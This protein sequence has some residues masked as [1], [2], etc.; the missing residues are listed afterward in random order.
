MRLDINT[1]EVVAFTVKLEKIR[2]S[3]L[4]SAVRGTLNNAAFDVKQ[5]TMPAQAAAAFVKRS[6]NFFKANS[7][8]VMATGFDVNRMKATV[9]FVENKLRMGSDHNFAVKDLEQQ[10][11]S[12]RIGGKSFIPLDS[13]RVSGYNSL[14]KPANRLSKILKA[15]IVI[16]RNLKGN[17]KKQQFI[18]A[19]A[20]AGQ[21]GYVIGSNIKGENILWRV[22]TYAG[23]NKFTL[24]PL[25]SFR[26]NRRVKVKETGFME[27]ATLNSAEKLNSF[28]IAQARFYLNKY[29]K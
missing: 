28:Y 13:A 18:R 21:G 24:T 26:K 14:V 9:G 15:K 2:K 19:V 16:A 22:D 1:N 20:K 29:S 8:V 17:S 23:P 5:R 25:Y 10:E 11:H 4:P 6:P 3:A 12:G 27:K 7:T